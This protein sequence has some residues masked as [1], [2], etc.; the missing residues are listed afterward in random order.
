MTAHHFAHQAIDGQWH[1][2]H[3]LP[4][5]GSLQSVAEL[6]SQAAAQAEA[7]RLNAPG[8]VV[9]AREPEECR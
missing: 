1:A 7:Q 6:P 9:A 2:V 3:R 8:A 5:C 4:G